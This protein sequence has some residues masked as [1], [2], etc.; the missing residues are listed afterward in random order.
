MIT[1]VSSSRLIVDT[2]TEINTAENIP[3]GTICFAKDTSKL[4]HK[5]ATGWDVVTGS[6]GGASA[7]GEIT[8]TLSSQ[9]DLSNALSGKSDVHSHP[10]AADNHGHAELHSNS[11]DHANT[12]DHAA[13]SDNQDLSGLVVK[14]AGSSLVPDTEITKLAGVEA[15]ANAYI[16]PAN[17]SPSII[18]QDSSN[19]FVTDTEKS[20]WNGK[21]AGSHSHAAGDVTGTAVV[22]NDARLSDARTPLSHAHAAS[23]ITGTAVVTG[24]SRLSDARTPT[25]H[26]HAASEI[27]GNSAATPATTG[28]MTV[29]MTTDIITITP[30]GACTFNAVAGGVIGRKVT[31][32]ITTSG[33]TSYTL[34]WGTNYR[35]TGT[36][37]TGTTSAR[38][39]AV[40]FMYVATNIWQEIA[41]TAVQT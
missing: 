40:S 30:T 26:G 33:T 28:T 35:K 14:V 36:L 38:F 17:H 34:T 8:G 2:E 19:R 6:A 22:D 23:D 39:F 3:I 32:V 18:T 24:D 9:T 21:A 16:H 7:W 1:I 10:Y 20:A 27:T 15:G 5:H 31:F 25:A 12:L 41:R 11:L 37:A 13:G 4:W 29:N